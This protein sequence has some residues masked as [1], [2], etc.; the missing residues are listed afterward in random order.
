MDS[1]GFLVVEYVQGINPTGRKIHRYRFA[2]LATGIADLASGMAGVF[3]WAEDMS[4]QTRPHVSRQIRDLNIVPSSSE[5]FLFVRENNV[6]GLRK[7]FSEGKA[8]SFDYDQQGNSLL[9]VAANLFHEEMVDILLG[10]GADPYICRIGH[11]QIHDISEVLWKHLRLR[12]WRTGLIVPTAKATR[13]NKLAESHGFEPEAKRLGDTLYQEFKTWLVPELASWFNDPI[14]ST[15]LRRSVETAM[16]TTLFENHK[17]YR[18]WDAV[19]VA[20]LLRHGGAHDIEDENGRTLLSYAASEEYSTIIQS[21]V[22]PESGLKKSRSL[23]LARVRD[24]A[25]RTFLSLSA[26]QD[27]SGRLD[28][29]KCLLD[30]GARH[31]FRDQ[32]GRTPLSYCTEHAGV[33]ELLLQQ[34]ADANSVDS[35]GRTPLSYAAESNF[36]ATTVK[37]L[38]DNGALIDSLDNLDRTPLSYAAE[39]DFE[40]AI[41]NLLL[42]KGARVDFHDKL[43]ATPLHHATIGNNYN[44]LKLLLAKGGDVN[45]KDKSG[46]RLLSTALERG[47]GRII[48]LVL[49]HWVDIK[50]KDSQG[51]TALHHAVEN[52]SRHLIQLLLESGADLE[53]KDNQ[54]RTALSHALENGKQKVVWL[55][56]KNGADMNPRDGLDSLGETALPHAAKINNESLVRL[57]LMN[58]ADV[59]TR[60]GGN[61][62]ALIY[63]TLHKSESLVQLLLGN[64]ANVNAQDDS[65]QSPLLYAIET[66]RSSSELVKLLLGNRAKVN[67]QDNRGRSPLIYAI[68]AHVFSA[69][70][71]SFSLVEL[72]LEN[73]ADVNSKD[74]SGRTTLSY[75]GNESVFNFL[76]AKGADVG[77][78]AEWGAN[79]LSYVTDG[80]D[81]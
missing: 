8:S 80:Y 21:L 63:A 31:D 55:L 43:G 22:H 50:S 23:D 59:N 4:A 72:L 68:E 52:N 28:I 46:R 1:S 60:D 73:G 49:E 34:G 76:V 65:G 58:G 48:R 24:D 53:S 42:E 74:H 47:S 17:M 15:V 11:P 29:V 2:C 39:N 79:L 35:M 45:I 64:G 71:L 57:L 75:A 10:E 51:R 40:G 37:I 20:S 19:L 7:L 44:S 9:C 67:V 13:L 36:E 62:T 26:L 25:S 5:T 78:K 77:S 33:A 32:H 3:T 27:R 66:R 70:P 30:H 18:G 54:G 14:G 41:V 56:L 61:K 69:S 38:L 16:W 81:P 12:S 6:R